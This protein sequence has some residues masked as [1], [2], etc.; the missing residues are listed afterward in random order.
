MNYT[1]TP[2]TEGD[3]PAFTTPDPRILEVL[4]EAKFRE[5]MGT[6]YEI[7][8]QDNDVAHFFPQEGEELEAA[9]QNS[10]DFF[11]QLMGGRAWFDERRG[12]KSME[13]VHR[14]FSITPKARDGW[15]HCMQRALEKLELE[16]EL[17]QSFWDYVEAFSKHLVNVAGKRPG[18]Y[19]EMVRSQE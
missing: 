14:R 16:A 6:F 1:I 5:F 2:L 10:S 7:I 9:K 4:G 12:G 17:K 19:E 3:L 15:L 13:Y 18:T 11:V 8:S